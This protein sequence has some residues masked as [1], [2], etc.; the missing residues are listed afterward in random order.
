MTASAFSQIGPQGAT[1]V[2]GATG[3]AGA[4]GVT[5][6]TG[7]TPSADGWLT[8]ADTWTYASGSGGGTATF[9]IAGVDRTAVFTKG[10]RIKLTQTT[11]KYF[12][13]VASSFSTDTTVTITAGSDY[14]LA[15]AAITSPFYSY[16]ANPQGYP[17]SFNCTISPTGFSSAPTAKGQFAVVGDMC[18]FTYSITPTASNATTLTLTLPIAAGPNWGTGSLTP[19]RVVNNGGVS[20]TMGRFALA[21]N[22]TTA[23]LTT[24][25]T[26]TGWDSGG[27]SKGAVGQVTYQI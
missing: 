12:V 5:G 14:T 9:T 20:T 13:V 10:T 19:F 4:T 24:D 17:G 2:T 21:V 1:G 3:A 11:V 23:T 25:M 22:S 6:A 18:V 7:T 8:S 16:M 26:G 27:G 15:N